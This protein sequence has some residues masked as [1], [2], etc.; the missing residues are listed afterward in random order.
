M[1]TESNTGSQKGDRKVLDAVF[2]GGVFLW[3]GLV[4]G[5][6]TLGYLPQVGTA[7]VWSWIFLGAGLY[8][9][10]IS[11]VRLLSTGLSNPSAWD[12]V[13]SVIFI[14]IG[15]AGFA[16]FDIPWWLFLIIIGAVILFSALLRRDHTNE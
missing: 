5:A 4:F 9:L 10:L 14:I 2:W 13:W 8:G 7:G 11:I 6:E 15:T 3:A 16:S 1:T 12:W